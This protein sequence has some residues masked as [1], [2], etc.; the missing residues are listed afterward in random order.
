MTPDTISRRPCLHRKEHRS[1]APMQTT[2]PKVTKWRYTHSSQILGSLDCPRDIVQ[3]SDLCARA[4]RSQTSA[5][6]AR[7][8]AVPPSHQS[9]TARPLPA[10]SPHATPRALRL[11][12]SDTRTAAMRIISVTCS[13]P[14]HNTG[15]NKAMEPI[16]VPVTESAISPLRGGTFC[17]SH[18]NGSS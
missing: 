7:R 3:T 5:L 1:K 18:S 13:F 15:A 12:R 4:R 2:S 10:G 16:R 8:K 14:I 9:D 17:A 6:Q 11:E